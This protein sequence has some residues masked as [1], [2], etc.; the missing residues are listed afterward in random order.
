MRSRAR[1]ARDRYEVD[2]ATDA[3]EA[4]IRRVVLADPARDQGETAGA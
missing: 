1:A 3:Y 4:L 2:R